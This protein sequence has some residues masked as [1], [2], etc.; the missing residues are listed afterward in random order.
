VNQSAPGSGAVTT[1]ASGTWPNVEVSFKVV[2]WHDGR[3]AFEIDAGLE[4]GSVAAWEGITPTA[5]DKVTINWSAAQRPPDHYSIYWT[6]GSTFVATLRVQQTA[7]NAS[8]SATILTSANGDFENRGVVAGDTVTL[9]ATGNTATV[10][11]VDSGTQLTTTTLSGGDTYDNGDVFQVTNG[12]TATIGRK[13]AEVN[14][15]LTTATID[16]PNIALGTVTGTTS[17]TVLIDSGATFQTNGVAA[18]DYVILDVSGNYAKVV[19]VDSETQLTTE[20]LTG[21]DTYDGGD[22]Y[23]VFDNIFIPTVIDRAFPWNPIKDMNPE[24][25]Q[26]MV[27]SYKGR[28]VKKSYALLSPLDALNF[29]VYPTS[30]TRQH[31]NIVVIAL[32]L[33]SRMRYTESSGANALVSPVDGYFTT[34]D[35][36]PTDFKNTNAI[37]NIRFEAEIGTVT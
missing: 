33:G 27:A 35:Y 17:T 7:T 25:R 28:R 13:V 8:A 26:A 4:R 11:V 12:A 3:E 30:M 24:L 1:P 19:S 32:V 36:M 22:D 23:Q 20:A 29:E 14:G 31:Y 9:L 10:S 5:N 34:T 18:N 16:D 2:A 6:L 21:A 37:L 15:D